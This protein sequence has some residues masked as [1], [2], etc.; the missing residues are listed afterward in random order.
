VQEGVVHERYGCRCLR[1]CRSQ[2]SER[3][4]WDVATSSYQIEGAWNEDG[5]VDTTT[6]TATRKTSF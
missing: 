5:D 3:F 2:V 4:F 6:V 1:T